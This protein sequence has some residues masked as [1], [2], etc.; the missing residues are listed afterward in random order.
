MEPED[1]FELD[2]PAGEEPVARAN[3]A[4][5]VMSLTPEQFDL[6]MAGWESGRAAGLDDGYAACEEAYAARHRFALRVM[7]KS[8]RLGVPPDEM[9]D[10]L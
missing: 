2:Y 5:D 3:R 10:D 9:Y 8:G 1:H 6:F 7:R 4:L